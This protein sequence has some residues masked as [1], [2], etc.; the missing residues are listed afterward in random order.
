MTPEDWEKVSE[1]FDAASRLS[2]ES[3]S[4]FLDKECAGAEHLRPEIESLLAA[5]RKAGNFI[6]EP[7]ASVFAPD[8]LKTGDLSIDDTVGPYR[9]VAKLGV[10]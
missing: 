9:L 2:E 1:V 5:N 7:A 4:G 6:S 3:V 8:V 10:G